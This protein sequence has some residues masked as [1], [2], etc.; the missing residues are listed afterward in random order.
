MTNDFAQKEPLS[1]SSGSG[2]S[3]LV[4]DE[5]L[6]S[7]ISGLAKIQCTVEEASAVLG[8]RPPVFKAFL[9]THQRSF[10][11]WCSG[12]AAGRASLRRLQFQRAQKGDARMLVW[13]GRQW[14]NQND[15]PVVPSSPVTT[16][17][18]DQ[19]TWDVLSPWAMYELK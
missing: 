12:P 1:S 11:A 15:Q 4:E 2:A 5:K 16:S 19:R 17:T 10:T 13:L 14:L 8:V 7:I 6:V 9:D 3:E 18:T